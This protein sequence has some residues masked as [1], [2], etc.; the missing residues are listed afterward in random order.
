MSAPDARADGGIRHI[1]ANRRGI[2][3][4]RQVAGIR[5][6]LAVPL[7]GY[8]GVLLSVEEEAGK[9]MC[10]IALVHPDP[11]LT[12]ELYRAKESPDILSV[13]RE[14]AAFFAK[15]ALYGETR[16]DQDALAGFTPLRPRRGGVMKRRP[17]FLKR[18]RCCHLDAYTPR[19][20]SARDMQGQ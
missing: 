17:R 13:W 14:W 11:E 4:E 18:R 20:Q 1:R 19:P 9:P 16:S 6:H 2:R 10:R 7:N 12:I 15:P 8:E 3:I 5:M